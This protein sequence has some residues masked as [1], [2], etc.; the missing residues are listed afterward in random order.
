[1]AKKKVIA[2]IVAMVTDEGIEVKIDGDIGI[3]NPRMVNKIAKRISRQRRLGIR[4]L[5]REVR[6][7]EEKKAKTV[8]AKSKKANDEDLMDILK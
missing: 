7:K 3:L 2:K 5:L 6:A 4:T 1:M 8:K